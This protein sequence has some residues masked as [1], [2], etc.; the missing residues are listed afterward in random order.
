MQLFPSADKTIQGVVDALK[1]GRRTCVEVVESSLAQIDEQEAKIHAWVN[2]DRDGALAR[3]R[4]LDADLEAG[5]LQGSLH[6]VPIGIKDIVDV[7]GWPTAA[8]SEL[9][10]RQGV[11]APHDA[12]LVRRLREAGAII[13]GKT[14]T[15]QFACFDP[16]ATRNPWNLDRTPGGSSS[17]S[18][19]AVA[20]GMCLAA[21]GSQ[22]G[23][24]IT[25]P[26]SFCGV[27]GCKPSFQRVSL[28]GVVPVAFS[29]DHPGP[30]ART[31][32]D[33]GVM[34]DVL[35]GHNPRDPHSPDPPATNI[36]A[37]LDADPLPAPKLG[38][39]GGAFDELADAEMREAFGRALS[40]LAEAGAAV[41]AATFPDD[42]ESTRRFHRIV[43]AAEAADWHEQRF[44]DHPDD[45]LPKLCRLI[46]DG[47]A[48]PATR[49]IE[50]RQH[51]ERLK[52]MM[53]S[54]FGEM[55][56]LVCPATVGPAPD[57]STTGDPV[58]NSPWS[59]TG[60]PVV[61]FPMSLSAD[62]LP[63]AIQLIGRPFG[64]ADLFRAAL[65]CEREIQQAAAKSE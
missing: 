11:K 16:P 64:E 5:R 35:S 52:R 23:G 10:A 26:T 13:L 14:V 2:V 47:L 22:T 51:Q 12:A 29:L 60:L 24:S 21:I 62:G 28:D 55:D 44:S 8:G 53:A 59:Y 63:L 58:F 48:I 57:A 34:L 39:L 25:R 33:L 9:R 65:W 37:A 56:V 40:T 3:A 20:A 18:A 42:F 30:I 46:E 1:S 61:S 45:Y 38:R 27:A 54:C 50:A 19:A 43:M 7:A 49:Y 41:G 36:C 31:V 4:Q 15:T 32:R 6:G 17:G